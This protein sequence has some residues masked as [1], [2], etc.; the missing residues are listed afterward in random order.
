MILC[1]YCFPIPRFSG[2]PLHAF[3]VFHTCCRQGFDLSKDD[4]LQDVTLRFGFL[5][6]LHYILRVRVKGLAWLALPCNSF[7]WMAFAQHQ[8]SWQMPY[9]SPFYA[10]VLQGNIIC[11]RTCLLVLVAIARSVTFFIENPLRSSVHTWPYINYLM[12]NTWLNSRRSSW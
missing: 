5:Q 7:G 12:A 2:V 10:W 3:T 11:S 4:V 9:G 6:A 1:I 8:R